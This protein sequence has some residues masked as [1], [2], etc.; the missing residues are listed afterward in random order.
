MKVINL[1]DTVDC[2][3]FCGVGDNECSA[4]YEKRCPLRFG[5]KCAFHKTKEQFALD[6][7]LSVDKFNEMPDDKRKYIVSKYGKEFLR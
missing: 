5:G 1:I 4:T 2:F 6:R 7:K 3:G